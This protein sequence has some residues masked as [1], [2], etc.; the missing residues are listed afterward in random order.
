MGW[1]Y[2]FMH[3]VPKN[4]LLKFFQFFQLKSGR[5]KL[6]SSFGYFDQ[7]ASQPPPQICFLDVSDDFKQKKKII[8]LRIFLC[9][10]WR[11][12]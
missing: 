1:K 2:I 8:E 10:V 5:Y 9:R 3:F 7:T 11:W 6:I 4:W 12:T